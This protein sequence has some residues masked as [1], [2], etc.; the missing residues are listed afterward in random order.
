MYPLREILTL[1]G[2]A[3]QSTIL[4][5]FYSTDTVAETSTDMEVMRVQQFFGGSSMTG[6]RNALVVDQTLTA[7]S[8][9][10]ASNGGTQF[11][12]LQVYTTFAVADNGTALANGSTGGVSWDINT[13]ATAN[14]GATNLSGIV[15]YEMDLV[16][17]A[18]SSMLD[19]FGL[20]VEL[21]PTDAVQGSRSDAAIVVR[22]SNTPSGFKNDIQF[23][24]ANGNWASCAGCTLINAVNNIYTPY[25]MP[26]LDGINFSLVT[27]SDCSFKDAYSCF[28]GNG[29]VS[30]NAGSVLSLSAT[31]GFVALPF[32]AGVPTGAPTLNTAC[33]IDT[34]NGYL[35]C[36][37]GG[38][39]HKVA[40]SSG[41]G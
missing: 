17:K 19:K 3:T 8:G 29:S 16:A 11:S 35:N 39:W 5:Y 34:T 36:Y 20:D 31:N 41:A 26:A 2:A 28:Y 13:V 24:A 23:G 38:A 40:F 18:G 15:G 1:T 30:L 6:N 32:T 7:T 10:S 14:S 27:F 21:L 9:N 12:G 25:A 37:Y 22:G 4:N 33:A